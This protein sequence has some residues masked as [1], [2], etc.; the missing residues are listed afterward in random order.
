MSTIYLG[1]YFHLIAPALGRWQRGAHAYLLTCLPTY[2][3][4]HKH[5]CASLPTCLP[6]VSSIFIYIRHTEAS[7]RP[8]MA[9]ASE[10]ATAAPLQ[11]PIHPRGKHGLCVSKK[12]C[13]KPRRRKRA[14]N[15]SQKSLSVCLPAWLKY[16]ISLPRVA[17][18]RRRLRSLTC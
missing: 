8:R 1:R 11:T 2:L 3:H 16:T 14:P 17:S 9:A 5:M 18:R 10:A 6:N 7:S 4:I 15:S 12:A 13:S